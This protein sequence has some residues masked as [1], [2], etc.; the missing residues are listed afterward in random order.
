MPVY[1]TLYK[2][3]DSGAKSLKDAPKRIAESSKATEQFGGKLIGLWVT[4]GEYD[5]VS[6]AEWPND[7]A[8]AT[9]NRQCKTIYPQVCMAPSNPNVF[10]ILPRPA[11]FIANN[12]RRRK[13]PLAGFSASRPPVGPTAVMYNLE[14]GGEGCHLIARPPES[15]PSVAPYQ[16]KNFAVLSA[17]DWIGAVWH[18]KG[19]S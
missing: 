13:R 3:T 4:M 18:P 14:S 5:L 8:A 1:V 9:S 7:E 2:W 16:Q 6:V 19:A 15:S 10:K 17:V 12:S 11:L